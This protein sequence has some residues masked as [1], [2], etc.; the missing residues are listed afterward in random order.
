ML[1]LGVRDARQGRIEPLAGLHARLVRDWRGS[2]VIAGLAQRH[3]S[4]CAHLAA[5]GENFSAEEGAQSAAS[6][7]FPTTL[8]ATPAVA[9]RPLRKRDPRIFFF[10]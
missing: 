7:L 10:G 4:V 5:L 3:P 2:E 1:L 6:K 8:N 9:G